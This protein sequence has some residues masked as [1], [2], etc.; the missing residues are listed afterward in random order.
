VLSS[1]LLGSIAGLQHA[2]GGPDHVAG[3]APLAARGG[4]RAWRIGLAWGIGH[5][6]GACS[7]A[8]L[9]LLL[10]K[11]LPGAAEHISRWSE[12]LVGVV[13]CTVGALGLRAL[14]RGVHVHN[15]RPQRMRPALGL[16]WLHGAAGLAH[17]YAVLPA[18][19]LP[20]PGSYL[21][22]YGVASTLAMS[23]LAAGLGHAGAHVRVRRWVHGATSL[24]SLL[25]GAFWLA[26]A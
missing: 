26:Q 16:G 13:L 12:V 7:A 1:L 2:L 14:S 20:H 4:A 21:A 8:A 11:V 5:A 18:L 6:L 9:A 23:A 17:L 15:E 22:G 25:V 10:S 19:A 24:A 3:V